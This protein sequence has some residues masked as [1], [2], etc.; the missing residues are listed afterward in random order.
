[1]PIAQHS[2]GI[3][4]LVVM[5][6]GGCVPLAVVENIKHAP[7][8][9]GVEVPSSQ[10]LRSAI[11]RASDRTGWKVTAVS[12]GQMALERG[13]KRRRATLAISYDANHYGIRYRDSEG[14]SY[15]WSPVADFGGTIIDGERGRIH[16]DYNEWVRELDLAIQQE[17]NPPAR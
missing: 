14:F 7:P 9:A 13:E 1:M 17:L 5:A 12:E 8:A 15:R 16:R 11:Q 10:A 3:L 4:V 2:W 6:L